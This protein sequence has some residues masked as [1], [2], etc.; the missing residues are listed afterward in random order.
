MIYAIEATGLGFVKIGKSHKPNSR[1]AELMTGC[2]APLELLAA[3]DWHDD[4]EWHIHRRFS[5]SR[6]HGEW[7]RWDDDLDGFLQT[8]WCPYCD[9]ARRL[10][11]AM[12]KLGFHIVPRPQPARLTGS[13][14]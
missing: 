7:F 5:K 2:P 12:A 9:E 8:M 3:R 1:M 4:L 6:V 11:L 10:D 14:G 13:N